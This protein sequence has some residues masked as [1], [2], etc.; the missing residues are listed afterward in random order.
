MPQNSGGM[1][2]LS[3]WSGQGQSFSSSSKAGLEKAAR[4]HVL[5][6]RPEPDASIWRA[7]LE[8]LGHQVSVD[9]LLLVTFVQHDA[10]PLA[11]IQGLI[12]TSRNGLRGLRGL[13]DPAALAQ[14]ASLPLYAVGP[15]TAELGRE[16]GFR[17]ITQGP[18]SARDLAPVLAATIDPTKGH[19]LHLSGDKIA[20]DLAAV[21]RPSGIRVDRVILYRS[22]PALAFEPQT[23]D[24]LASGTLD[25]VAL[26]SPLSA[27][28]F[29]KLAEQSLD[30]EHIQRL[31]YFCLSQNIADVFQP[32][33]PRAVWVAAQPNTQAMFTLMEA[34]APTLVSRVL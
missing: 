11:S 22:A 29:L 25:A 24:A 17:Q 14:A 15:G 31:V 26:T 20:Y 4:V 10:L 18:A 1:P 23:I 5:I 34:L 32:I 30:L 9:P 16:L 33:T 21:L 28:T 27:H 3:C 13:R 2:A 6:T 12:A 7:Q 8:A 19:L